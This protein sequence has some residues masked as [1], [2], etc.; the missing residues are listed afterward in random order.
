M[1]TGICGTAVETECFSRMDEWVRMEGP[2]CT[3]DASERV[4][5]IG[6]WDDEWISG[7]DDTVYVW[8]IRQ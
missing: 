7:T 1:Q 6:E 8:Q 5:G 3:V 4:S 2:M